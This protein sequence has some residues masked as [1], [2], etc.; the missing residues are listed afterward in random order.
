MQVGVVQRIVNRQADV[1]A[2]RPWRATPALDL[3]HRRLDVAGMHAEHRLEPVRVFAAEVVQIAML[4]PH[5][6]DVD[7]WVLVPARPARIDQELDIDAFLVHVVDA[8][9][10]VPVVAVQVWRLTPHELAVGPARRGSWLRLA[11]HAR[12]VRS[13]AADGTTAAEAEALRV[14]RVVRKARRVP[15]LGHF[16]ALQVRH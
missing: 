10:D 7:F 15:S 8:A 11:E 12:H 13:P 3:R 6:L 4:R 1:H 14:R 2:D 16:A 9:V 5:E